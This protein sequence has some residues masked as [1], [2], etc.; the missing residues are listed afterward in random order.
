MF[1]LRLEKKHLYPLRG[2]L[3]QT[4]IRCININ[5]ESQKTV[6]IEDSQLLDRDRTQIQTAIKRK[7]ITSCQTHDN[8][9]SGKADLISSAMCH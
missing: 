7:S 6:F 3:D 1:S 4:V 2:H 8:S 9:R 5:T